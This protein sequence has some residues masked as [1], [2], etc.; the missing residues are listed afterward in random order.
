M[1]TVFIP[2]TDLFSCLSGTFLNAVLN[3]LMNIW[4]YY[5]PG[6]SILFI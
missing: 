2:H 5:L 4:I 1:I 3:Y 6:K